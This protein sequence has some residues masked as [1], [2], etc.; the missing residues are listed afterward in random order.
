VS[1]AAAYDFRIIA[2]P[3]DGE[4]LQIFSTTDL[5]RPPSRVFVEIVPLVGSSWVGAFEGGTAGTPT[6]HATPD[7]DY[8]F[9]NARGYGYVF[10]A[11]KPADFSI[12]RVRPV[13]HVLAA[14]SHEL[15][16]LADFTH[17]MAYGRNGKDRWLSDRISADGIDS[18]TIRG[19]NVFGTA[20]LPGGQSVDFSI[21]VFTGKH[22]GGATVF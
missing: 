18:L 17:V 5:A 21:D 15:L 22:S 20:H 7:P 16:L 19:D 8:A 12:V 11:A 13:M 4:N 10:S 9:V 6:V 3:P 14:E 2:R 1:F